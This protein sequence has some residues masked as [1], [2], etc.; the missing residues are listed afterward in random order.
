MAVTGLLLCGFLVVHLGGNLLLYV[1]PEAYN[2]Y[3]RALHAQEW[4]VK[5]AEVGLVLLFGLHITLAFQT[6]RQNRA[7][8]NHRYAVKESKIE[9]RLS[10][11]KPETWMLI[12]GVVIFAFLILHLIDFTFLQRP[13]IDYGSFEHNEFA[14]AA[15]ILKT[16]LSALVYTV[17]CAVL[18]FHLAHGVSSAFQT[19][20]WNHPRYEPLIRWAGVIFAVLIGVGFTSFPLLFFLS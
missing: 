2:N 7:A 4:F 11:A 19:L 15:A 10:P 12:S 9:N 18:G 17:G 5:I 3:A 6:A 16:P 14:K 8:R 1:G 13:D 20:G